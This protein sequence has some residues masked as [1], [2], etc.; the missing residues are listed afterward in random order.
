MASGNFAILS[1]PVLIYNGRW[2]H[3]DDNTNASKKVLDYC[4]IFAAGFFW[5]ERCRVC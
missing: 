4:T 3:G 2:I 1:V 5:S